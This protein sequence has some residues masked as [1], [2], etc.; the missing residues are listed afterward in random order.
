MT[1]TSSQSRALKQYMLWP[2]LTGLVLRLRYCTY[3]TLA[4]KFLLLLLLYI[5]KVIMQR[6]LD[7][8]VMNYFLKN[9]EAG[10]D[11]GLFLLLICLA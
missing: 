6:I 10:L 4:V 5:F 9:Q 7:V 1:Y 11:V 3:L 2:N 8:K